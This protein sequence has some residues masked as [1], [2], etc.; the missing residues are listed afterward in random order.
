[1]KLIITGVSGFI[2]KNFLENLPTDYEIIGLY[3]SN[4]E[5]INFC[6][7]KNINIK[8]YKCDLTDSNQVKEL[9]IKIGKEFDK[10]LFLASNTS[11]PLSRDNPRRDFE[12]TVF[13]LVN[14]LTYFNVNRFIYM[15]TAGVY[16]GLTGNVTVD[17]GLD[18]TFPYCISKLA[19]EYYVKFYKNTLNE[20]INF[21]SIFIIALAIL[22]CWSTNPVVGAISRTL[23]NFLC[24]QFAI[25]IHS[26]A[27]F[28]KPVGIT[29]NVDADK[30]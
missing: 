5:I 17:N 6:K 15:S 12:L 9:S 23:P 3:Y 26:T 14:F 11:M 28:P 1:M 27:V 16:D 2:G 4:D 30:Q 19:A 18:P 13:T 22:C 29:I 8:L 24:K 20:L 21:S 25:A 7:E 10:C